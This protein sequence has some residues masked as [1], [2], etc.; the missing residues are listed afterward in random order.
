LAARAGAQVVAASAR[1]E[2]LAALGAHEMVTDL[3]GVGPLDVVLDNVGGP[4]L[5]QA[6]QLSVP[7]GKVQCVGGSSGQ[8]ATFPPYSTVGPAKGLV[9][10]QAGV[11][12]GAD[13]AYLVDLLARGELT[14][15]LGWQGSWQ[16]VDRHPPPW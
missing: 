9:S 15:D 14:V 16:D 8:S 6:W 10:F 4:L 5:V 12:F 3:S 11:G 2:G 1:T 13:L 7:G